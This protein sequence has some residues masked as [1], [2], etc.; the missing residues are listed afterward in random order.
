MVL[1]RATTLISWIPCSLESPPHP[2]AQWTRVFSQHM[3]A[4]STLHRSSSPST[5]LNYLSISVRKDSSSVRQRRELRDCCLWSSPCQGEAAPP[6]RTKHLLP[7]SSTLQL[8]R[9]HARDCLLH[10]QLSWSSRIPMREAATP[11]GATSFQHSGTSVNQ[12]TLHLELFPC[13]PRSS[14]AVLADPQC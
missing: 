1:P 7:P 2:A 12:P 8:S 5:S 13:Q 9:V 14:V 4:F 10:S 6:L 11:A 3:L